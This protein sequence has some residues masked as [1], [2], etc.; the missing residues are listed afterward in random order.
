ML[1]AFLHVK[2]EKQTL[3]QSLKRFDLI[4]SFLS[5]PSTV[6]VLF[7]LTYG[8]TTYPWSSWRVI[9]P[10]VSGLVG[11]IAFHTYEASD[12]PSEPLMPPRLFGS[13][14][15]AVAYFATLIHA[16]IFAWV[17]LLSTGLLPICS[18]VHTD[19]IGR[20]IATNC[21]SNDSIRPCCCAVH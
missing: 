4:A 15:S 16:L 18:A 7:A 1:F 11:L 8:G 14:T 19:Q 20:S 5:I 21:D 6:A 17:D 13:R 3:Q 9:V 10:L 2:Y 12:H